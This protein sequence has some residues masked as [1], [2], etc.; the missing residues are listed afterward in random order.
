M[1]YVIVAILIALIAVLWYG[2]R[3]HKTVK[4]LKAKLEADGTKVVADVTA[5]VKK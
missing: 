3:T 1:L 2:I 5:A 4:D